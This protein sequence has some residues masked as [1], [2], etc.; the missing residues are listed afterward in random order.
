[1][2]KI[3]FV[4]EALSNGS[5]ELIYCPMEQMVADLLTKTISCDQFEAFRLRMGLGDLQSVKPI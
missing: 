1:M 5:I 4:R 2:L 3:H